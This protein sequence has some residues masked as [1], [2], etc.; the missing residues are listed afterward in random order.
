M[1]S[2]ASASTEKAGEFG[3]IHGMA[4]ILSVFRTQ[5]TDE[6]TPP[7][8]PELALAPVENRTE[9]GEAPSLQVEARIREH[10]TEAPAP[11]L[12][13]IAN[14]V[15]RI[16]KRRLGRERERAFGVS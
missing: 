6:S 8:T 10:E 1:G 14:D 4:G 9:P 2:H 15:Y 3:P 13:A 11:D 5:S 7:S 12:E 16:L